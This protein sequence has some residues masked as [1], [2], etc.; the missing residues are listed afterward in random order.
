M[1]PSFLLLTL[2]ALALLL[3]GVSG[4]STLP[5][6]ATVCLAPP[7]CPT[8]PVAVPP[9]W[10]NLT[11]PTSPAT[12]TGSATTN[13]GWEA[14]DAGD[15]LCGFQ[16]QGILTLNATGQF[17]DM[18][19]TTGVNS[20]G[21]ALPGYIGGPGAGSLAAGTQGWTF[22]VTVRVNPNAGNAKIA[23]MGAGAPK[24]NIFFSMTATPMPG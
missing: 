8:T 4:Q 21:Y 11:F 15:A 20:A 13:F 6:H 16:H 5:T 23:C 19:T 18:T 7:T 22:E 3:S 10:Y 14:T 1:R 24:Y 12:V 2:S 17:V 9:A